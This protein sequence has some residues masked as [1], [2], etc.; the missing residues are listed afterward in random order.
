MRYLPIIILGVF[1]L[2]AIG[3][4]FSLRGEVINDFT[5]YEYDDNYKYKIEK[6]VTRY[7]QKKTEADSQFDLQSLERHQHV[8]P[9]SG[10]S[11][12]RNWID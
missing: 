10:G 1:S 7:E 11:R 6:K 3:Y 5:S 8:Q 12:F 4:L 9:R 2:L